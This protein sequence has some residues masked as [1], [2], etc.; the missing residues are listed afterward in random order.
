[1]MCTVIDIQDKALECTHWN[2]KLYLFIT[3]PYNNIIFICSVY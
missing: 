1:M 2:Y 3:T